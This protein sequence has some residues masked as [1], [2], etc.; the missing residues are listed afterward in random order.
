MRST[1]FTI[2]ALLSLLSSSAAR[3]QCPVT[4]MLQWGSIGCGNGQFGSN[5]DVAADA[6]HV[7]TID[8]CGRVQVFDVEGNYCTQWGELGLNPY[9]LFMPYGIA[10]DPAGYVYVAELGRGKVIKFTTTGTPVTEWGTPGSGPGQFTYPVKVA[11][12]AAGDVYVAD[13]SNHRIQKFTSSGAFLLEWGSAGSGNGQFI[14]PTGIA[15]DASGFVYVTDDCNHRVQ[16]FTSAGVYVSQWGT[17]GSGPGEFIHATDVG[18]DASGDVFVV[19]GFNDACGPANY[20]NRVQRFTSAGVYLQEWGGSGN[21]PGQFGS[22]WGIG[23]AP[24]SCVFYV[25][26]TDNRRIQR[27]G[28]AGCAPLCVT[29]PVPATTWGSLK[30]RYR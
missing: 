26:D 16:K 22:P 9:N 2:V 6:C 27:F 14:Y 4:S 19:E 8:H 17:L 10:L 15:I 1:L 23:M 5:R 13:Y 24:G 18:V 11:L 25:A 29:T 12:D 28:T 7:Y 3:G 30:L 21:A 20:N